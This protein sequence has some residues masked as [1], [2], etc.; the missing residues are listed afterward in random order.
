M[1]AYLIM[2]HKNG[3][4]AMRLLNAIYHPDNI[5][6]VHVDARSPKGLHDLFQ[7]VSDTLPNVHVLAPMEVNRCMWSLMDVQLEAMQVLQRFSNWEYFINLSGQCFPLETQE[8]IMNHLSLNRGNHVHVFQESQ[9]AY[10]EEYTIRQR[11]AYLEQGGEIHKWSE[12]RMLLSEWSE[13]K[14]QFH[15]GSNWV[16][17][18]RDF[19]KFLLE[20][21]TAREVREYIKYCF[22]PDESY[23]QTVLLNSK[24]RD[25]ELLPYKR[26]ICF[27][28]NDDHPEVIQTATF[29]DYLVYGNHGC[30][31]ARKFDDSI[32]N[33]ML[34][35]L[36]RK[37]L[38][39]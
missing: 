26:F 1:L 23:I 35:M 2:I 29:G 14:Y 9:P 17:L 11:N 18:M 25:Q 27:Q 38:K 21:D 15:F 24:Y 19:V 37:V 39:A 33:N 22:I 32:D 4:Q 31:F 34:N 20:S 36:E 30:F 10:Q 5:Y 13:G 8:T 6:I 28:N 12:A 3:K 16:I 7:G